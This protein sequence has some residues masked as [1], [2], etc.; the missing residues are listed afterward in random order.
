[1]ARAAVR[2]T[3]HCLSPGTS[4]RA[5]SLTVVKSPISKAEQFVEVDEAEGLPPVIVKGRMRLLKRADRTGDRMVIGIGDRQGS[6]SQAG[7]VST[8]PFAVVVLWA[9]RLADLGDHVAGGRITIP[10]V[11]ASTEGT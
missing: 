3:G 6:A 10:D 11:P 9:Y 1:M 2:L 7:E 8:A 5:L 4:I